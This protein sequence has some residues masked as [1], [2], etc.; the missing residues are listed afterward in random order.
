ME[1]DV[2]TFEEFLN[3]ELYP[4]DSLVL[5]EGQRVYLKTRK[6]ANRMTKEEH[7]RI[8]YDLYRWRFFEIKNIKQ[9]G[10]LY[11]STLPTI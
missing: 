9:Y 1:A 10:E 11:K 4:L 3:S 5:L 8:L 7:D 2:L 6:F